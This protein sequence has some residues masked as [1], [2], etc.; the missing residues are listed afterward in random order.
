MTIIKQLKYTI[1]TIHIYTHTQTLNYIR[2]VLL[3]H[4]WMSVP[5]VLFPPGQRTN[6]VEPEA[7]AGHWIRHT[8]SCSAGHTWDWSGILGAIYII[9]RDTRY[10]YIYIYIYIYM[11]L[12]LYKWLRLIIIMEIFCLMNSSK[13]DIAGWL[14][15]VYTNRHMCV[16]AIRQILY[17]PCIGGQWTPWQWLMSVLDVNADST[18]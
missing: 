12:A 7:A 13:V 9:K 1:H 2:N 5:F 11:E 3:Y 6:W 8:E 17:I 16:C 18:L 4:I 10:T 15:Y 14:V